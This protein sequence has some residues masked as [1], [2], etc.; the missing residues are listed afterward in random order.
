MRGRE[1]DAQKEAA[2]KRRGETPIV[3]LKLT[4]GPHSLRLVPSSGAREKR[5]RI[6]LQ[7]DKELRKQVK[8]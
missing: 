1:H 6:V 2:R 3:K 5:F 4:A 7:P 8:W